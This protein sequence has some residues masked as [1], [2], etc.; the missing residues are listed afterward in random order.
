MRV[1]IA[2]DSFGGTLSA[3]DAASAIAEGWRA[4]APSTDLVL[5]PLADGGTGFL[6]VLSTVLSGDVHRVSVTGPA[7]TPVSARWLAVGDTAYL[8]MAEAAGLHLV[9]R[10]DRPA[11][12]EHATTFGVGELLAAAR[13]AGMRRAVLGLGGSAT[14]DGGSG[15][16][17]A[18][19]AVPVA[20]DGAPVPPGGTALAGCARL[21]GTPDVGS[22]SLVAAA[23]VENPL[24]GPHGAVHT[25]GPQKGADKAA[26][27]R[28]ER[29]MT[30]WADVLATLGKDVRDE[31]GAGAAGGLG[32]ALLAL[33]AQRVS[34]AGLVRELT[35]LDQAVATADLV[36]TGEGS[37]DW[38]SLRGK[39]VTSVAEVAAARGVPV[40]VLA[41]QVAVG[42]R[43][44]A[45]VGVEAMYSVTEHAGSVEASMADPAGTLTALAQDV[46]AEWS[47]R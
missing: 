19:G 10:A 32:A 46:A 28:L 45:S 6:D 38:Q 37:F 9:A 17:A 44:A 27:E 34:G 39:L 5:R 36:I 23:D 43:Q 8:E 1:L 13:D 3:A 2:P 16:L 14:T 4:G 11:L 20:E 21:D 35:G 22:L 40:L 15:F 29:A 7:G 12:A 18:L 30:H 31:P 42:R 24:L 41:G 47:R 25:F 26:E 33:G